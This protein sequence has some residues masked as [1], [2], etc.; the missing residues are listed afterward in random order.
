MDF[1]II[2]FFTKT[3]KLIN[4][5]AVNMSINIIDITNRKNQHIDLLLYGNIPRVYWR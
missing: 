5:K 1:Y 3:I 4:H 2:Q